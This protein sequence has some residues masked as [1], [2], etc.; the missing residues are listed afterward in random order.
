MAASSLPCK[1]CFTGEL[2][3]A[4][5]SGRE[6]TLH[7]L[8]T[9]VASPPPAADGVNVVPKGVIVM[10]PD[11]FGWKMPNNRVLCDIYAQ[12]GGYLVL[13]PDF[14]SGSYPIISYQIF[15]LFL[16]LPLLWL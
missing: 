2:T 16:L 3:S 7:G 15:P 10:V 11:A 13:L 9:Y 12:K 14:M 1:D 6:T 5:P 4:V 8:S